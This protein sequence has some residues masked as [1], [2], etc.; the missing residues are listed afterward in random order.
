MKVSV[1]LLFTY[2]ISMMDCTDQKTYNKHVF[3]LHGM[4]IEIQGVNAVSDQFGDYRYNDI[5]DSLKSTGAVVHN[6]VRTTQTDFDDF[7]RKVSNQINVLVTSGVNPGDITVIGASKGAMMSMNISDMN[8]HPINYV[9]LGAN[10]DRL[11]NSY[12]WTLHGYI[13]GIYEKS[14]KIAG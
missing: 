5:I 6:E 2:L 9:L 3:Y 13:L 12:D 14:D 4:I 11:E 10:S 8:E 1:L 7:C